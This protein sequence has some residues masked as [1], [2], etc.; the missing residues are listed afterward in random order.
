MK[1]ASE[2]DIWNRIRSANN[3]AWTALALN[4]QNFMSTYVYITFLLIDGV[5]LAYIP[6][7]VIF[8][9]VTGQTLPQIWILEKA[10]HSMSDIYLI[11]ID[12]FL[13]AVIIT[14]CI[15]MALISLSISKNLNFIERQ[16]ILKKVLL[17]AI[18]FTDTVLIMPILIIVIR[19]LIHNLK[20]EKFYLDLATLIL[21]IMVLS[22]YTFFSIFF[23]KLYHL[24]L[25]N[26]NIPW[27]SA[28]SSEIK[29]KYL[30]RICFATYHSLTAE[31]PE[32]ID[33]YIALVVIVII[34]FKAV[35]NMTRI[36]NVPSYN[37]KI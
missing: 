37:F 16:S 2:S 33:K 26:E 24:R 19:N 13:I 15:Y 32:T 23:K 8:S 9:Q 17:L 25:Y 21:N 34:I 3:L 4:I 11:I 29:F 35:S 18:L 36:M 31:Y 7:I 22:L 6:I 28:D 14:I 30:L 1:N 10:L 20:L 5:I 27:A 12:C